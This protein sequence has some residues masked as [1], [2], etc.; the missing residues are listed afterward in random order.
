MPVQHLQPVP[1]YMDP[2]R[3]VQAPA[4]APAHFDVYLP[5]DAKVTVDGVVCPGIA[6]TRNFNTAPLQPGQTYKYTFTMEATQNG[7]RRQETKEI[8]FEAGKTVTV[9]FLDKAPTI[10]AQ[11]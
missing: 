4:A 6:S 10:T 7:Q 2:V 8:V 9:D 1:V 5:N 11:R 3:G